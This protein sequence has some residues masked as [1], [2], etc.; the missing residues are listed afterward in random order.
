MICT[1]PIRHRLA[2]EE[3]ARLYALALR[4]LDLE[5]GEVA[6]KRCALLVALGEA[7]ARAGDEPAAKEAFLQA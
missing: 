6:E 1:R 5:A 7:R 4:A 2:Y 3:A